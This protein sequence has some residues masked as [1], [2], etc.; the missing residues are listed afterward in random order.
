[1][2]VKKVNFAVC[3]QVGFPH[4][5]PFVAKEGGFPLKKMPIGRP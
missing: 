2:A 3:G 4:L 1:M 5:L